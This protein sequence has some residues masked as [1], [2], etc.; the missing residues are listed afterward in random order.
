VRG[1]QGRAL[2]RGL[3]DAA[4][5]ER[6]RLPGRLERRR[7]G[8]IPVIV[9]G[10]HV[11]SS[12][13]LVMEELSRDPR[14]RSRPVVVLALGRDKD[15][16]AILKTLRSGADRLVCTTA[17]SG[18]L[19]ATGTLVEEAFRAGFVAETAADP[20]SALAKATQLAGEIPEDRGWVLV[21][22]SFYLAG[23]VR[24]LLQADSTKDLRC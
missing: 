16:A 10:A 24:P 4:T 1:K 15:A 17:A 14:L 8:R 19:R 23:A 21:I 5:I 13:A 22:G 20:A 9:D 18:P 7:L 3:L 11:A 2:E 12:I 6:A